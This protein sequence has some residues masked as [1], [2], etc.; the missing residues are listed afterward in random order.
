MEIGKNAFDEIEQFISKMVLKQ[1]TVYLV[2]IDR[3]I[4][5]LLLKLALFVFKACQSL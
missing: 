1:F 3:A 5:V 4:S 2:I